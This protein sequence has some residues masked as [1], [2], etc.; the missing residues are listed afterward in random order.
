[1]KYFILIICLVTIC[2][3]LA[4]ASPTIVSISDPSISLSGNGK[5]T[6]LITLSPGLAIFNMTHDGSKVFYIKLLDSEG[7]VADYL[8][9]EHSYSEGSKVSFNGSKVVGIHEGGLFA[10]DIDADGNWTVNIIQ[11]VTNF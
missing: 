2:S 1:M 7:S 5:S 10:L 3:I 11:P 8:V 9:D 4:N 6:E